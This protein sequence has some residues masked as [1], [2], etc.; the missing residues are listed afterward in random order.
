VPEKGNQVFLTLKEDRE[1]AKEKY[2][3]E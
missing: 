1:G 3:L 2:N